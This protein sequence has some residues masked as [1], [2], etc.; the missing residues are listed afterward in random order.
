MDAFYERLIFRTATFDELLSGDFEP[1]PGQKGDTDLAARRLAA[2]SLVRRRLA[3]D[4]LTVE[5]VLSRFATVRRKAS[6]PAPAWINDAVWIEEALRSPAM[7]IKA[8]GASEQTEPCAFEGLFAPVVERAEVHLW[9]NINARTFAYFSESARTCLRRALLEKLSD[10]ATPA[11]FDRFVRARK[12]DSTSSDATSHP[13]QS[14]TSRYDQFIS[15]MKAD[16]FRSLFEDKPVLLRLMATVT[17]QWIDTSREFVLRVESD[18]P[19]IRQNM[20]NSGA[21]GRIVKIEGDISDPHN[22]GHSVQVI[23]F[24]DGSRIVYKP[25]D[26]RLDA[27]WHSLI[28]RLNW[29]APPVDL[30]A[31]YALAR[32]RYGWAEFIDHASCADEEG[33]RRFFRRAGA[34]LALFHCFAAS[35]MHQENIIA[36]GDHPVPIDLETV[37]QTTT[38]EVK[39]HEPEDEAYEAAMEAVANS[40]MMVGLLPGYGRNPDNSVFA[41]GGMTS[42]WNYKTKIRWTNINSDEMRPAKTTQVDTPNPNLPHVDGRYAR[43]GDYVD[44]FISGFEDYAKFL[45]QQT[46]NGDQGGI[47]AGFAGIPVRKVIRLTRFYY[48][49]LMR[50]KDHRSMEDGVLWSV[51]ADFIARLAE[52]ENEYDPIWPLQKAERS[53]LL[54]LNVPYF[55]VQGDGNEV[56]DTTGIAICTQTVSGMD[57]ARDRVSNFS[58]RQIAWQIEIIRANTNSVRRPR[59]L[60]PGEAKARIV[61][62]EV[63]TR[64]VARAILIVEA[65]KI[66]EELSDY[67]IRRER[68][69]AWIGLDWLGD[70]EVFQ[71]VC[72]G[73]DLYNGASGIAL[74]LAAHAAVTGSRSSGELALAA[75]SHLRKDLKSRN[76]ARQA[77]ALGL[78]G[79]IGLGS[80]VYALTVMSKLLGNADL[81]EDAQAVAR[82][83]T[84]ELVAAD[85]KLDVIGGSAGAILGL[86]RLYRDSQSAEVLER[87]VKCGDHLMHQN[88]IGPAGRGSWVGQGFGPRPLNGMSHGAAGFAYALSSLSAA[89]RRRDFEQAASE[90]V[91]FENSSYSAE[92][93][94]WPDLRGEGEPHWPCQ[95]CHGASG[96]GLARLAM[97][98]GG[99]TDTAL[100]PTDV[101]NAVEGVKRAWP[102]RVDTL[103]CGTLGSIELLR[104]AGRGLNRNDLC[105]LASQHLMAVLQ[106]A[107][108]TGDY[109][110]DNGKRKF[111]LGLFRGLAGVGYTILRQA[112]GSLPNVL[113]WE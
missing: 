7:G 47:F 51:Q 28:G 96:I 2:W 36:G 30:K 111:N 82:L 16:G 77:R 75:V 60:E 79:G 94:N 26:L 43:F 45:L 65:D 53:A 95:W 41:M 14:S 9:S 42:D 76:G 99:G 61:W 57:R 37:F 91:A 62:R 69:A 105:E 109:R 20:L 29:S 97:M 84:D 90:C 86:L 46:R 13:R 11:I 83:I 21:N 92:R 5:D 39:T 54:A 100:L 106:S 64:S 93:N 81:L 107:G 6:A 32:D 66:A 80:V 35:D 108:S 38:G 112:D 8:D 50:L 71:L 101:V 19:A 40:V 104:E 48:M 89:T 17:R 58:D 59:D 78:G 12:A 73:P 23:S 85:K 72:L 102:N 110:W 52:W 44:D 70:A 4:G 56:S 67:A 113:I 34:W 27:S 68:S 3:R 33:Y 22:E 18:M 55:E 1:V 31:A 15:T 74:F 88:R 10:I 25:K 103:C 87:A 24:E 49:L 63:A 98:G